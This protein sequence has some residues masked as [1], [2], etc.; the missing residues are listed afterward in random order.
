ML[1]KGD[2]LVLVDEEV[3]RGVVERHVQDL[4]QVGGRM[5]PDVHLDAVDGDVLDFEHLTRCSHLGGGLGD[6]EG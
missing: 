3:T 6:G 5:L 2:P 1:V 4:S